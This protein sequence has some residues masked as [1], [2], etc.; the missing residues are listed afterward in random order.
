[1]SVVLGA[2]I[3]E[4]KAAMASAKA[5]L[6]GLAEF[7]EGMKDVGEKMTLGLSLPI[8]LA[9]VEAVRAFDKQTLA[10]A[11][12]ENGL[13]ST[14]NAAK[15]TSDQL[16]AMAAQIQKK[17]VYGD[18]EVL[19]KVTTQLL[20]FS[21]ISG[22][23]F[24]R[25]Q[26]AAVD[27]SA[28]LG[29]D[30][31]TSAI[32]LGKALNDPTQSLGALRRA[33]ISFSSEQI[34]VIKHLQATNELGKAQTMIL[35]EL[36]RQYG[37]TAEAASKAGMGG[38]R[39]LGNQVNDLMESLGKII[40]EALGPFI[41]KLGKMV[42]A[43]DE[44]SDSTKKT[45]VAVL[46][47]VA[48]MGPLAFIIGAFL[49]ILPALIGGFALLSGPIMI[50]V[51][52]IAALAG[53]CVYAMGSSRNLTDEFKT[54]KSAVENLTTVVNP[55]LD[56][57][58]VLKAK[59]TLTKAEQEELRGIVEKVGKQIPT[60]ITAFD[61]Y[62]KA[63]DISSDAARG[64]IKTQQ[65]ILEVKN[66]EALTKQREEYGRLTTEI[67]AATTALH[68]F[69]S[70][71]KLAAEAPDE[72][73]YPTMFA[74]TGVEITKLQEKLSGLR[75]SRRGVGGLIDE[76]KGIKPAAEAGKDAGEKMAD[77]FDKA[78]AKAAKKLADEFIN[79][80][81]EL[82]TNSV[83]AANLPGFYKGEGGYDA[84]AERIK[85]LTTGL[86]KLVED[87]LNPASAAFQKY[88]KELLTLSQA[89]DAKMA[90]TPMASRAVPTV[91]IDQTLGDRI[92]GLL[93]TEIGK[94]PI[95]IP[96]TL[97]TK[98]V[99][100]STDIFKQALQTADAFKLIDNTAMAFG[101]SSD[102]ASQKAGALT[103]AMTN[104]LK[105][106]V[107]PLDPAIVSLGKQLKEFTGGAS[108]LS[109]AVKGSL[110][111][112]FVLLGDTIGK[113]M[114]GGHNLMESFLAGFTSIMAGFLST[115]GKQ[116]ISAG[117][118]KIALEELIKIPGAGPFAI[119]AGI[120]LVALAG[121]AS[122]TLSAGP[123]GGSAGGS[124]S[125]GGGS[126]TPTASSA[127][128]PSQAPNSTMSA[129]PAVMTHKVQVVMSGRE[130][131]GT[132]EYETDRLGR[133]TG[134]R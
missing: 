36:E 93:G 51:V 45:I 19:Q 39:Q 37:G 46:A 26:Q 49:T 68:T 44:L 114:S 20:T 81:N 57:Y 67:N 59:T 98:K 88:L 58:D 60:T 125:G 85:I 1:M 73:G 118:G 69:N 41:T 84:A 95:D 132:L 10:V 133:A 28:K 54:Q 13:R 122:A 106:G 76:L 31:Q 100:F 82:R 99:D 72:D 92:R 43:F 12:V 32:Q 27:L 123:I 115:F 79:L 53:A 38:L 109:M 83:L 2:D 107:S 35:N 66:H 94:Q 61:S 101:N 75:E 116:L 124:G 131:R 25:T 7:G 23:T 5:E 103:T 21:N 105:M 104:L 18:E 77:T 62:G 71:G 121:I 110:C 33:G 80:N 24:A 128:T 30:L 17:S 91:Q 129:A 55:L 16:Q 90:D 117:I 22:Q 78:A 120:A 50:A 127:Y 52:A 64:F 47:V 29:Q 102:M 14:G 8:M 11:Q 89:P 40:L 108:E 70:A 97:A 74:L 65:E 3:S 112:S 130:L 15:L 4:F 56:R 96:L 113:A 42:A 119:A 34:T 6:K 87:G 86:K 9:G 111:D 48:V 134:G 63:L 126:Y